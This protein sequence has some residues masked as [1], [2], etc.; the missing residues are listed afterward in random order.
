MGPGRRTLRGVELEADRVAE[1]AGRDFKVAPD[2][3][4]ADIRDGALDLM[5]DLVAEHLDTGALARLIEG[6]PPPG[7]PVLPPAGLSRSG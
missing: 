1:L 4:F 5:A 7:L 2:T 6:G 3:C